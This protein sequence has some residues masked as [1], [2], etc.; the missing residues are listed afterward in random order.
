MHL[1]DSSFRRRFVN[2]SPISQFPIPVSLA[3]LPSHRLQLSRCNSYRN[4]VVQ[5]CH[6]SVDTTV[7]TLS[8]TL[9]LLCRSTRLLS[10]PLAS[11]HNIAGGTRGY[12]ERARCRCC[13]CVRGSRRCR[14]LGVAR[15][16]RVRVCLAATGRH[17]MGTR[18][19]RR[20]RT[21]LLHNRADLVRVVQPEMVHVALVNV[22]NQ[23]LAPVFTVFRE[24]HHLGWLRWRESERI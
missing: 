20:G 5:Q 19:F 15:R 13:C 18:I 23:H 4:R 3:A 22:V 16:S 7:A 24:V 8:T 14:A 11:S 17:C 10:W 9:S 21:G 6:N 2:A 12:G 1:F